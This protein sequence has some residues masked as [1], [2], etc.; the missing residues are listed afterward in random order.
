MM[1]ENISCH[2]LNFQDAERLS[3]VFARETGISLPCCDRIEWKEDGEVH[4]IEETEIYEFL[5]GEQPDDRFDEFIV[6]SV[7][8]MWGSFCLYVALCADR[9]ALKSQR[10]VFVIRTTIP[11]EQKAVG[12]LAE[13]LK[14]ALHAHRDGAFHDIELDLAKEAKG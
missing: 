5:Y 14:R 10:R 3:G 8:K 1:K 12:H 6:E 9:K 2:D 7:K 11:V 13:R 4:F